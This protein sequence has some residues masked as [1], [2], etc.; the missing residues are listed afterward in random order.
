[1]ENRGPHRGCLVQLRDY[2]YKAWEGYID[3]NTGNFL[4]LP[5]Y[6]LNLQSSKSSGL[7]HVG[8]LPGC[9]IWDMP[10]MNG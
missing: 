2:M 3:L 6:V 4:S 7:S 9:Q 10:A 5:S 1:M 8:R